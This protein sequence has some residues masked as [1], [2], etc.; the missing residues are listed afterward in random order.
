MQRR[1]VTIIKD[2]MISKKILP[3]HLLYSNVQIYINKCIVR[4]ILLATQRC[5]W[6]FITKT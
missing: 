4:V 5:V 2:L 1:L 6:L 3:Q